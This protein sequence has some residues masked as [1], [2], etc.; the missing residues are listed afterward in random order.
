MTIE[1]SSPITFRTLSNSPL[2]AK[3]GGLSVREYVEIKVELSFLDWKRA[4]KN[5]LFHLTEKNIGTIFEA[6][7]SVILTLRLRSEL[8]EAWALD[9]AATIAA[10]ALSDSPL[11]HT[12]AWLATEI[13]QDVEL[14]S[15]FEG[16]NF[17]QTGER[18]EW[19]DEVETR[20]E[21]GTV[22]QGLEAFLNDEKWP[23]TKVDENIFRFPAGVGEG[24]SWVVQARAEDDSGTCTL[25]SIFPDLIT[26]SERTRAAVWM[27]KQ[28]YELAEGCFDM[29]FNDGEVRYRSTFAASTRKQITDG[30]HDNLSMMAEYFDALKSMVSSVDEFE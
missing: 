18:T 26:A 4:I 5:R 2:L 28:N 29:D 19:A 11:C 30:V 14:P 3:W 15:E 7:R 24:R 9:D 27:T 8:R 20:L 22:F 17:L 23:F 16:V 10:L 6:D 21:A 12:E 25:F 13:M 1:L